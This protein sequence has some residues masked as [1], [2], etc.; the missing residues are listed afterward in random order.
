VTGAVRL[1]FAREDCT[2]HVQLVPGAAG[3]DTIARRLAD[4]LPSANGP[5]TVVCWPYEQFPFGMTLDYE[6]KFRQYIPD[7]PS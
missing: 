5:A 6:R 2:V 7:Q 3:S 4:L 1:T